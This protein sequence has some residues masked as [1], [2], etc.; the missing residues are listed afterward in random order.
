[1]KVLKLI[2]LRIYQFLVMLPLMAVLTAVTAMTVSVGSMLFGGRIWGYY[3]AKIWSKLMTWISLV[4]VTVNGRE[5]IQPGQS[6]V[7]VANHQGAYDIFSIYGW[8]NHNFK[9][10]MK[11]SL[12]K[13]PLVGYACYRAGHIFVDKSSA[14]AIHHTMELAEKQLSG[15]MSVVVFPEGTRSRTGRL[16]T[17]KRGAFML[18]TEFN[19]PV[20]PIT[21]DGAYNVMPITAKLPRPGHITLTLHRPIYPTAEGH[22]QSQLIEASREA[23]ASA[24]PD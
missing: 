18:A 22:D 21:I 12:R 2:F 11:A 6:Y 4:T 20:V 17:F 10:M 24:L 7:F 15:G 13:I 23:I 14:K 8:L 19:L 16:G 3:P 9:W 1:M 5:N